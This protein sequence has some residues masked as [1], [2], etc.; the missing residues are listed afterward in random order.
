MPLLLLDA[1]IAL[2]RMLIRPYRWPA[3]LKEGVNRLAT[4]RADRRSM[5]LHAYFAGAHDER[6]C[7][8]DFGGTATSRG[9]STLNTP[10][11][12]TFCAECR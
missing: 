10:P 8:A 4:A 11:G 1:A 5:A 12:S 7:A 9:E 2:L 3:D 6:M